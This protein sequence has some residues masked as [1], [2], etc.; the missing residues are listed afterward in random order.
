VLS[1]AWCHEQRG[2]TALT[3]ASLVGHTVSVQALIEAGADV[4]LR[5]PYTLP[6]LAAAS[7]CGHVA[8]VHA[9][10]GAGADLNLLCDMGWTPLMWASSNGQTSVVQALMEAGADLGIRDKV[11]VA[12]AIPLPFNH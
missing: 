11:E 8:I 3:I 1:I 2:A 7:L 5:G 9:L 12:R 10:I 4:N 6:A